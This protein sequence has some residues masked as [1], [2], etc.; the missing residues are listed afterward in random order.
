[1]S[2][3]LYCEETDGDLLWHESHSDIVVSEGIFNVILGSA[4]TD[5]Y[6]IGPWADP[7]APQLGDLAFDVPYY[8]EIWVN[9]EVMAPRKPLLSVPYG[10]NAKSTAATAPGSGFVSISP[11]KE[12]VK[13][14]EGLDC[15]DKALLSVTVAR[16]ATVWLEGLLQTEFG[17]GDD[18]VYLEEAVEIT[19]TRQGDTITC[20][21][22]KGDYS[23]TFTVSPAV[24]VYDGLSNG[25]PVDV[26][27]Q[28]LTGSLVALTGPWEPASL[29]QIIHES[30]AT[31]TASAS[32]LGTHHAQ[33]E[34][35]V[36]NTG[37]FP[38]VYLVTVPVC[39][40]CNDLV[41]AQSTT[42]DPT[43][44]EIFTFTLYSADGFTAGDTCKVELRAPTGRLYDAQTVTLQ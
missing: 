32:F 39:N 21:I 29:K 9:G 31:C 34:V 8:L 18:T 17:S 42:L 13:T 43:E 4:W 20:T 25:A 3:F 38:S 36:A 7:F 16:G 41:P 30:S 5:P 44:T 24:P 10:L 15:K 35:N 40:A 23:F 11:Y 27:G 37:D 12:C 19:L 33:L 22:K 2:F 1:M 26:R 28:L 14:E 6:T